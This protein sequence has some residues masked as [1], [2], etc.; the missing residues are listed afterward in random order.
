MILRETI[1]K[2]IILTKVLI[3]CGEKTERK[4]QLFTW[5]MRI[6]VQNL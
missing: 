3:Y 1:K 5:R 6:A 4:T 2:Y